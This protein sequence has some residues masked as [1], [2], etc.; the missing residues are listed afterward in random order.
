MSEK[1]R[2]TVRSYYESLWAGDAAAVMAGTLAADYIEH[3]HTADFCREGLK[4]YV[5]SRR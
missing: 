5:E 1:N 4:S 3:Q 2:Q